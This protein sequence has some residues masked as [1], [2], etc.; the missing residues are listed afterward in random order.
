MSS[1]YASDHKIPDGLKEILKDFSREVLRDQ[2]ANIYTYGATYFGKL[3]AKQNGSPYQGVANEM[4]QLFVEEDSDRTGS[5]PYDSFKKVVYDS[6]LELD[7]RISQMIMLYVDIDDEGKLNYEAFS[8]IAADSIGIAMETPPNPHTEE[9][10]RIHIH[11]FMKEELE[12]VLKQKFDEH[13]VAETEEYDRVAFR[14][15][16]Q[17]RDLGFTH[18]EINLLMGYMEEKYADGQID[19]EVLAG[20]LTELLFEA[21]EQNLLSLPMD[22]EKVRDELLN[23]YTQMDA[24][25]T[26]ELM[27]VD[28]WQGLLQA[29]LGFTTTQSYAIM[30]L[31]ADLTSPVEYEGFTDYVASWVAKFENG[32]ELQNASEVI[33]GMRRE[34]LME[35]F[36]AL[37][38]KFNEE[39]PNS[40]SIETLTQLIEPLHFSQ[41]EL[42]AILSVALQLLTEEEMTDETIYEMVASTA[43]DVCY[44]LQRLALDT[45]ASDENE[46]EEEYGEEEGGEEEGGEEGGE[47]MGEEGGEEEQGIEEEEQ[48]AED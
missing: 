45:V 33:A 30:G 9:P 46:G 13:Q 2:P 31:L 12:D 38:S 17:D 29:E 37:F 8:E 47:E 22:K 5:L 18:R 48:P 1:V 34:E 10:L 32:T 4:H 23:I 25:Q 36:L 15:C 19:T 35:K 24:E 27:A 11:G 3:H 28:I 39:N 43:F 14:K 44:T 16:V 41:R 7:P 20:G 21:F 40:A 6:R 26:G 42:S